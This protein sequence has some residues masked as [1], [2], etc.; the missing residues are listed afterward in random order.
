M[1]IQYPTGP[2]DLFPRQGRIELT[3]YLSNKCQIFAKST[4][5]DYEWSEFK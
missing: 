1:K 4:Q 2:K 3:I 5:T